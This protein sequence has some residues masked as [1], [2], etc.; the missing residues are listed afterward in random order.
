MIFMHS[1]KVIFGVLILLGLAIV[2]IIL[3]K[4]AYAKKMAREIYRII[5]HY[6]ITY[7][8]DKRGVDQA[9]DRQPQ[10]FTGIEQ[11]T[12]NLLHF[13]KKNQPIRMLMVGFPFKSANLEKKV[14]GNLPDMA[15]RKS[16]EYLQEMLNKIKAVY[17]P[18]AHIIIFCDGIPF[19]EFLGIPLENVIDYEN[20]LKTIARDLP[21]I[22]FIT[23]ENMTKEHNLKSAQEIIEY[24]DGFSPND[25]E[26]K[27]ELKSVPDTAL[28]RIGLELDHPKGRLLIKKARWKILLL[29]CWHVKHDYA[30]LLSKSF[31][32]RNFLD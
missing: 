5:D 18:G 23:S 31:L 16:L 2:G 25:E 24:I 27:K 17:S 8:I 1:K 10:H 15:E 32:L 9:T 28:K 13:I 11:S 19:A 4:D 29:D 26:Y 21:D 6:R 3:Y 12:Q 20:H 14:I 22:S 30:I 7:D